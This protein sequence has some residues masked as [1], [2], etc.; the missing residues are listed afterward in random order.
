MSRYQ[1]VRRPGGPLTSDVLVRLLA[2]LGETA[3]RRTPRPY[4]RTARPGR[5]AA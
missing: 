4:T 2:E 1:T 5:R 3:P